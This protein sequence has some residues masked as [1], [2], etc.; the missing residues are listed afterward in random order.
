MVVPLF[1]KDFILYIIY[2]QYM[3]SYTHSLAHVYNYYEVV[4]LNTN[5]VYDHIMM[6]KQQDTH[7]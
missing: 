1:I 7:I 5:L 4:K 3:C 6:Y 2:I